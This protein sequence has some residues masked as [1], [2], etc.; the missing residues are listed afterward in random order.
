MFVYIWTYE[1]RPEA[2]PE[3]ISVYGPEGAWAQLFRAHEGYR[4]TELLR[5]VK[6]TNRFCT[7]DYWRSR[8]DR[9]AFM[10]QHAEEFA[11]LDRRC[12]AFTGREAHVGDFETA[13]AAGEGA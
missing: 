5:D 9:E 3:F 2:L 4:R 10:R 11:A 13:V 8:D 1:V 7:V 12:E 6:A